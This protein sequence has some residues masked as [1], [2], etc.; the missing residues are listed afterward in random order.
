MIDD[1][2]ALIRALAEAECRTQPPVT[3]EDE[4][5]IVARVMIAVRGNPQSEPE[6]FGLAWGN[7]VGLFGQAFEKADE[8]QRW[9]WIDMCEAALRIAM[10]SQPSAAKGF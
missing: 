9:A 4:C 5:A 2:A 3:P 10:A 7:A 8:G 6:L 1:R